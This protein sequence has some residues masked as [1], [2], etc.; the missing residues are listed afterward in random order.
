MTTH[1]IA[2]TY[3]PKI[4]PVHQGVIRQTIRPNS[5]A[6]PKKVDDIA[7]LFTWTGK[8]YRSPWAWRRREVIRQVVPMV[9]CDDHF[10]LC[11]QGS[12]PARLAFW[13]EPLADELA[14]L[15]GIVPATGPELRAVLLGYHPVI[16]AGGLGMQVIRW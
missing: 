15:D 9:A 2:I 1:N 13:D 14:R 5:E 12:L 7:N 11:D 8:P 3:P 6:K 4:E 10:L 16:A